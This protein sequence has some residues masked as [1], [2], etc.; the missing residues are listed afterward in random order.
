MCLYITGNALVDLMQQPTEDAPKCTTRVLC[1]HPFQVS[2][3]TPNYL[4]S[5][6]LFV[7][8]LCTFAWR[9]WVGIFIIFEKK[10]T[11]FTVLCRHVHSDWQSTAAFLYVIGIILCKY[12]IFLA[13]EGKH[14]FKPFTIYT[15]IEIPTNKRAKSYKLKMSKLGN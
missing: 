3:Y 12:D 8:Q 1:R 4:N 14:N 10:T 2:Y 7:G 13:F 5:L 6:V 15:F 11:M 9:F